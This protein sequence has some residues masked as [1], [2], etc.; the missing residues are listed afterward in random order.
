M[1][2]V[3]I[4]PVAFNEDIKLKN[5]VERFLRSPSR[6]SYDYLIV[7]DAST[8]GT[9]EMIASFADR[10]VKTLRHASRQGVGAAI[11]TA[12]RYAE[13]QRY[14]VLVVM[15]GNDKDNPEEI[16]QLLAPVLTDGADLVQGSRY[17]AGKRIGG[18]MPLYRKW[19]TR[20]HP[21]L[22]SIMTGKKMTDTTN[23]F[24]AMRLSLLQDKRI[25]LDQAWLDHYE[26]EPY[27]LYKAVTLGYRVV[28]VGVSKIYP[29]KKLGYTKMKPITG[30]WSILRPLFYL[31]LGIKK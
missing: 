14:D 9:T 6:E 20:L 10:G 16:P 30:W 18:D 22:F 17:L 31:W 11:R 27:I 2:R 1:S 19:A 23:G 7:D 25:S 29:A 28:E 26:L 3:L 21:L 12:I 24:R 8:D 5:A 15:A 13:A 4:C